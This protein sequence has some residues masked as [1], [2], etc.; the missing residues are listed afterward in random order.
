MLD[1]F[2]AEI[3]RDSTSITRSISLRVAYDD[4]DATRSAIAEAVH[5]GFSHIVLSLSAPY[6]EKVARWVV[7]ELINR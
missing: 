5:A 2:C 4:P 6:P 7:D 1:R 3:G